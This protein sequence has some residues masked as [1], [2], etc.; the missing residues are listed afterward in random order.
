[1]LKYS[2]WIRWPEQRTPK[3]VVG[4][5]VPIWCENCLEQCIG[6]VEERL[7]LLEEGRNNGIASLS[8]RLE[9]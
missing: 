9:R 6:Y 2:Q 1:M 3:W 5:A 4:V 8:G 7:A